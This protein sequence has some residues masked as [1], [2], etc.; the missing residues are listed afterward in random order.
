M[1]LPLCIQIQA[2]MLLMTVIPMLSVYLTLQPKS[3][4][5]GAMLVSQEMGRLVLQSLLVVM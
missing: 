4:T 3:T 2:A 1:T 5:V